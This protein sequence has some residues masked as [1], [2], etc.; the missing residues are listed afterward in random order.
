MIDQKI[1]EDV[2]FLGLEKLS[3]AIA[4]FMQKLYAA[5]TIQL[6]CDE[7]A[8]SMNGTLNSL[9]GNETDCV[10][11]CELIDNETLTGI[12]QLYQLS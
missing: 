10:S 3:T 9:C 1:D 2:I 6:N 8:T 11:M 5:G 7:M 12:D 4:A